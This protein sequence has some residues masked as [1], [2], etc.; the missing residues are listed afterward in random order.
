MI[1]ALWVRLIVIIG[2]GIFVATQHLIWI[3]AVAVLLALLTAGQLAS[4]YKE[5]RRRSEL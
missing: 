3:A 2:F 5:K 4:A 1:P